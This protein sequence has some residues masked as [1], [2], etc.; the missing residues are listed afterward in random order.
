MLLHEA[1]HAAALRLLGYRAHLN[2]TRGYFYA[3]VESGQF[4]TRRD[5]ALMSLTPLTVMTL[6]G[7]L[8][9]LLLPP[10]PGQI[11]LLVLLLNA[12]ASVGDLL[13]ARRAFRYPADALFT[14]EHGIKVY[15]RPLE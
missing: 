14:D 7:G 9:L 4:L 11:L 2:Y 5:Y 3:T 15:L 8:V 10:T 12:A 1:L 13:V 6:S